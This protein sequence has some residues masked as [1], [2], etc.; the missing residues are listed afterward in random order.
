MLRV[1]RPPLPEADRRT[2]VNEITPG[3]FETMG[4]RFVAGRDFEDRDDADSPGVV[5]VNEA[6]AGKLIPGGDALGKR[7]RFNPAADA[8]E[9]VGVVEAGRYQTVTEHDEFAVWIPLS[10]SYNSTST[11]VARSRLPPEET[12]ALLRKSME[13]LDPD[14]TVFDDKPL[15]GYL[16]LPT[17][18][19]RL[20]TTAL[21]AMGALAAVLSALGLHALVAFAASQR[22]REIGI[23]VALGARPVDV[24]RALM[25]RTA[26]VVGVSSAAGLALSFLVIRSLS[27]FLSATPD[28]SANLL[29]AGILVVTAAVA[30]WMPSRRALRIEPLSALRYE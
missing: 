29:A 17:T 12:L 16:D 8:R 5:I 18:P 14:L 30:G 1:D 23:R 9:I 27:G 22:T 26:F 20:I 13:E 2:W 19:L 6:I 28:F 24:I 25:K 10:Q 11:L 4:T 7:I 15:A 21:S 3:W